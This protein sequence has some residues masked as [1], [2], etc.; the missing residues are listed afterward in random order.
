MR[1][2]IFGLALI[3]C[4][5]A[6]SMALP[7]K[8]PQSMNVTMVIEVDDPDKVCAKATALLISNHEMTLETARE[9]MLIPGDL[10]LRP[11]VC[12]Q[13]IFGF[14]TSTTN[15]YRVIEST[16]VDEGVKSL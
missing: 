6:V 8:P 11:S 7:I 3:A 14:G 4:A 12:L 15:G 1:Y 13:T 10:T 2:S 9:F 5:A 16:T